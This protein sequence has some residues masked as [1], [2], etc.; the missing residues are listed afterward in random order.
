MTKSNKGK[1]MSKKSTLLIVDDS[2]VSRMMIS[3]KV[4]IIKPSWDIIEAEDGVKAIEASQ[5]NNIDFYSIDLTMPGIDGLE[6]IKQLQHKQP[7]SKMVLMTAN[8]QETIKVEA[9]KLGAS[10]IH[11]PV[12]DKS[13]D[14]MLKFFCG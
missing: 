14:Q 7:A 8:I 9:T 11:K 13:I 1:L 3:M 2:R 4:K 10:C 5:K 6:V 12:T